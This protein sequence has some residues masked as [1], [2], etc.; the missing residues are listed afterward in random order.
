MTKQAYEKGVVIIQ[1]DGCKN[2]HLI[3]DHLGWFDSTQGAM[4]TIEDIMERKGEGVVRLR[5]GGGEGGQGDEVRFEE[6]GKGKSGGVGKEELDGMMEWL[7][8]LVDT[9]AEEAGALP[10]PASTPS[11]KNK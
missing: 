9:V 11:S 3:A 8:K 2:R 4:G 5:Y 6:V 10:P 7:P 1:C